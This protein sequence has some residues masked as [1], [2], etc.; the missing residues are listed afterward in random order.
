MSNRGPLH[1]FLPSFLSNNADFSPPPPPSHDAI[2]TRGETVCHR[3]TTRKYKSWRTG[4]PS[5]RLSRAINENKTSTAKVEPLFA[6]RPS[7]SLF[8][9]QTFYHEALRRGGEGRARNEKRVR[10][11]VLARAS[12][13]FYVSNDFH[14][15]AASRT[16]RGARGWRDANSLIPL[17][18]MDVHQGFAIFI[19]RPGENFW[20]FDWRVCDFPWNIYYFRIYIYFFLFFKGIYEMKIEKSKLI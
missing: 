9:A 10:F 6:T 12:Q 8:T 20:N 14:E 16:W 11:Y 4:E 17:D 1:R 18:R 5:H 2:A 13:F 15:N 19:P 3:R 7:P